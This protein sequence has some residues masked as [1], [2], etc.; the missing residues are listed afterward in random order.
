MPPKVASDTTDVTRP[1]C[2]KRGQRVDVRGHPGHD[3]AGH[4]AL[5]EVEAEP[6]QV[7]ELPDAQAV[8][9]RLAGLAG[10]GQL[11][12]LDQVVD[13]TIDQRH[14]RSRPDD[15]DHALGDAAVDAVLDQTR[16]APERPG[17]RGR[18]GSARGSAAPGPG[19]ACGSAT[20]CR[21]AA[22]S[23]SW[24]LTDRGGGAV[25]AVDL[26][27]GTIRSPGSSGGGGSVAGGRASTLASSSG[28]AGSDPSMLPNPPPMP[29]PPP[30]RPPPPPPRPCAD[31][32]RRP[33][34]GAFQRPVDR[35]RLDGRAT[36]PG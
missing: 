16:E 1:V 4:L 17:R 12:A 28:V 35:P 5:V 27:L 19:A 34:I 20:T 10:D 31:R 7:G 30:P 32:P 3:A 6:L 14:R 22:A 23:P 21:A 2:R 15:A 25:L 11:P 18:S 36:A 13:E 9:N 33:P 8:E 24:Q 26:D 29:P